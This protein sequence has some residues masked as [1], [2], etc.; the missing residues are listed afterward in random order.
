M[1]TA[2][3]DL[4]E[5]LL[6]CSTLRLIIG[7]TLLSGDVESLNVPGGLVNGPVLSSLVYAT[8][9]TDICFGLTAMGWAALGLWA[10][11]G[12]PVVA[13][14][15]AMAPLLIFSFSSAIRTSSGGEG[16]GVPKR[17]GMPLRSQDLS[18][19]HT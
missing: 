5:I 13:T 2:E 9:S 19:K 6:R 4:P 3:E 15:L 11:P 7:G 18:G 1:H 14:A 8:S 17:G 10:E 16:I 12:P